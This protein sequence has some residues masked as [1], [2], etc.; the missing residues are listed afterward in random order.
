MDTVA[1]IENLTAPER[2]ARLVELIRSYRSVIVAYSG[3][4][5]STYLADVAHDALGDRALIVTAQSASLATAEL[6]FAKKIAFEQRW[7]F[8]IVRTHETEDPRYLDNDADRCFFCKTELFTVL[9]K[10]AE[11]EGVARLLYGAIPEDLGDVRPGQR[12]AA[13][14]AVAAPLIDVGIGKDDIRALSK[15][16]GLA[17]WDKPQAACLASRFP[18]GTTISVEKLSRVDR[19]ESALRALGF[20]GHRVR[21]HGDLARIELLPADW[22][23]IADR[24]R[25]EEIVA[26]LKRCGYKH[27]TI[28]LGGYRPAGLNQ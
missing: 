12:A 8:R 17:S 26:A 5:D 1:T 24:T 2:E 22:T 16:R 13:D 21:H 27:V 15:A 7:N 4:V 3:G 25:C 6:E 18:T 28:D 23:L 9:G 11:S 19:A 14:F 10:L 20:V